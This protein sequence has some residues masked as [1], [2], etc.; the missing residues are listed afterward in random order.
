MNKIT[1]FN[2]LSF[3]VKFKYVGYNNIYVKIG[4]NEIAEWDDEKVDTGWQQ[5][6]YCF[7]DYNNLEKKVEIVF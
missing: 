4:K 7:D 2:K 6:C 3:G 5:R 1:E